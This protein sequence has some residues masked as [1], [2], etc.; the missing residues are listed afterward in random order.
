MLDSGT[1]TER[2]ASLLQWAGGRAYA[3]LTPRAVLPLPSSD[4][5]AE[6]FADGSEELTNGTGNMH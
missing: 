5:S 1:I 3:R 6:R 4:L 2:G